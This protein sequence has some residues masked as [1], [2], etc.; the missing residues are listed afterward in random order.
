MKQQ[1]KISDEQR[2]ALK[3]EPDRPLYVID[4]NSNDQYVLLSADDYRH[5]QALFETDQFDISET[6]AAQEQAVRKV[7]DEPILDDYN[8]YEDHRTDS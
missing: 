1:P 6:Y 4:K 8:D 3:Q 7:W 2:E 5:F